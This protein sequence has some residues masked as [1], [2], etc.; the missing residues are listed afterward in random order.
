[1]VKKNLKPELDEAKQ[2]MLWNKL[3]EVTGRDLS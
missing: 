1:M 2:D 3:V